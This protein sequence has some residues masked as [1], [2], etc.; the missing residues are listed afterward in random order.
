M[1][2][3][4]GLA[5][6]Y[7]RLI[8]EKTPAVFARRLDALL[9]RAGAR[10]GLVLDLGCGTGTVMHALCERGYELIGCDSSA[11]MLEQARRRCEDLPV[12]PVL[13]CQ[14]MAELDLYG[15][16]RAAYSCLD[17]LNYLTDPHR[18][19]TAFRRVRLFL[20]PG[21]VFL[22]DVKSPALFAE[23]GGTV[24]VY[25]DEDSF[26]VWQYGMPSRNI[27]VHQVDIFQ[28][29]GNDY[30]RFSEEHVQRVYPLSELREL[31]EN[32]GLRLT[33]VYKDYTAR[34]AGAEEGRLLLCAERR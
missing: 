25:E 9:S 26:C 1:I 3:Y 29:V 15:T 20:E 14:D 10:N 32:A 22:F 18:L 27:A 5:A 24:S 19:Q 17:T 16:V 33:R 2:E 8:G 13:I 7:D 34:L 21:G 28:T 12:P 6:V 31:L 11:E 4:S 30:I 23:Q